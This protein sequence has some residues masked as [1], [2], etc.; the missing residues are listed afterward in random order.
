[1]AIEPNL[2]EAYSE[3]N[4]IRFKHLRWRFFPKDLKRRICRAKK[5]LLA[6]IKSLA[7]F[8]N[9]LQKKV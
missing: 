3:Q 4:Q 8:C 9:T 1:M 6:I 2:P 5:M 7:I